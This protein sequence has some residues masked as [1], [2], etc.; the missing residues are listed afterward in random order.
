MII[1]IDSREKLPL[2]FPTVNDIEVRTLALP[3]G[4]YSAIHLIDGKEIPDRAVCERKNIS[5]LFSAFAAGYEAE[6]TKL[7]RAQALGL[8]Y[9]LA[10]EGSFSDVLKGHTYWKAGEAHESQKSGLSQIRQ[11]MSLERRYDVRCWFCTSRR[12]M[13][14]WILEYF[15]AQERMKG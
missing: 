13:A 12:E 14:L 6:K 1:L 10:I 8:T 9:V 15:L 3:V 4:D 7:L 5:D 11:L 2:T